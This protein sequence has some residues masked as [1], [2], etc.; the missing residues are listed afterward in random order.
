M[1]KQAWSAHDSTGGRQARQ[2]R[3]NRGSIHRYQRDPLRA[4]RGRTH[5]DLPHDQ[6]RLHGEPGTGAL[7]VYMSILPSKGISTFGALRAWATSSKLQAPKKHQAPSLKSDE[8]AVV[9]RQLLRFGIGNFSGAWGLVLGV[10]MG[11]GS[12]TELP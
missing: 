1:G 5:G 3:G 4:R 11:R 7:T 6:L 10:S 12:K 2:T 8:C 9:R